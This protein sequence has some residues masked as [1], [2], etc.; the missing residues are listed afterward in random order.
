MPLRTGVFLASAF[1]AA[2]LLCSQAALLLRARTPAEQPQSGTATAQGLVQGIDTAQRSILLRH[3]AIPSFGMPDMTMS[4]PVSTPEMLAGR[5]VGESV[6][7]TLR[8]QGATMRVVDLKGV[9][10]PGALVH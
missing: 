7:F 6:I 5:F 10:A 8:K 4:F 2:W 3:Q 9:P 1:L